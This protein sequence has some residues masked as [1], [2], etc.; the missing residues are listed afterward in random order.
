MSTKTVKRFTPM[1]GMVLTTALAAFSLG[2]WTRERALLSRYQPAPNFP[3]IKPT[4]A[5][6]WKGAHPTAFT[7]FYVVLQ[8]GRWYEQGLKGPGWN[9]LMRQINH[10]ER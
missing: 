6:V 9:G 7:N 10:V 2:W 8:P 1:V 3:F 5:Y 4:P